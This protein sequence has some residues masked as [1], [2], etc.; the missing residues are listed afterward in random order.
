MLAKRR[1]I[2]HK[3]REI[4]RTPLLVPSFSS[5]G[6]PDVHKII[7]YSSELIDGV[8]LVSADDLYYEKKFPPLTF[9]SLIFLDSGGYETSKDA[10]LSDFGDKAHIPKPWTQD[11]HE[12]ELEKWRPTVPSV[13]ISYD[14]PD[15]RLPISDQIERGLAMAPGR[16]DVLRE[17]LLK[18]ETPTQ[19]LLKVS[20]VSKHVHRLSEFD[21][22]GVT[23]KEIGK[24]IFDRMKN[25]AQLRRM[26]TDAGLDKPIHVFGSLD[27][28]TTPMYFLA[29]AD[30]FDGLTWLRFAFH[31][32]YTIY[33]H[34]Y[35]ALRH[36]VTTKTHMIDGRCWNDNYYYLK[37]LELEMRRYLKDHDTAV[38]RHHSKLFKNIRR[39][40]GSDR[41]LKM[42]GSGGGGA[43][44]RITPRE[45]QERVRREENRRE[46]AEFHTEVAA[47]L[48]ELLGIYNG[49]DT[50]AI[51][52]YLVEL[53]DLLEEAVEGPLPHVYGGSVARHT[54]VNGMSDIDTLFFLDD[55]ELQDKGPK[56]ALD[57]MEMVLRRALQNRATVSRGRMAITV[58]YQDETQIQILPA[59][60]VGDNRYLVPSFVR[61]NSWSEV[62]PI[63]FRAA[64]TRR[65]EECAG[66]LVP[67]IKLVKA[68][69]GQLPGNE[70]FSG[71][72]IEALAISAFRNYDGEMTTAAMLPVFFDKAQELVLKPVRDRTGQSVHVDDYLGSANSEQRQIVSHIFSRIGRRFKNA[73]AAR[74]LA[75]WK[76]LFGIES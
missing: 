10:E 76:A 52:N 6:F 53:Q 74:S 54:Y 51:R 18:P 22:I 26:M 23:E 3:E 28:V 7:E 12:V 65:N 64:L 25:I 38:F 44:V 11:M 63:S 59:L 37:E 15:D 33:K 21:I 19:T 70:R 45:L 48:G 2:R 13:I 62:D 17:I 57:S 8:T 58:E 16:D 46:D 34:N 55:T 32:G 40:H 56:E 1:F 5:K 39:C 68:I 14:H 30:I 31:E 67:T 43:F 72:H 69:V 66:K 24:S 9:P 61:D 41:R 29:G 50:Q 49:R 35:G 60:K 73:T 42:G 75:Q 27:T 36:G 20:E 71:Y 47:L 4:E